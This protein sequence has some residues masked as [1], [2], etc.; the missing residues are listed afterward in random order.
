MYK[1]KFWDTPLR[2]FY[3]FDIRILFTLSFVT[4]KSQYKQYLREVWTWL[5][6]GLIIKRVME[7]PCDDNLVALKDGNNALFDPTNAE[8]IIIIRVGN[9]DDWCTQNYLPQDFLPVGYSEVGNP[10]GNQTLFLAK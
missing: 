3:L 4:D 6:H 5:G 2:F 8:K 9:P 10:E 1:I 7:N